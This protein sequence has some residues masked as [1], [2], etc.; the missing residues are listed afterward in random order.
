MFHPYLIAGSA[1]AHQV[2]LLLLALSS[3]NPSQTHHPLS[4][5]CRLSTKLTAGGM[6]EIDI[7]NLQNKL[8][9]MY[10]HRYLHQTSSCID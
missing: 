2:N 5:R 10:Y 1:G 4:C 7:A 9:Y 3:L 6:V 8:Y